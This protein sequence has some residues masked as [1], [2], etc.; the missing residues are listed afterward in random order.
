MIIIRVNIIGAGS[1]GLLFAHQ[2]Q[3]CGHSIHISTRSDEQAHTL[4]KNGV[5]APQS[6]AVKVAASQIDKTTFNES[7]AVIIAVKQYHLNEI[8]PALRRV[9]DHI[10]LIFLQNGMSHLTYLSS[11]PHKHIFVSTVEHGS[12]KLNSHTYQHNGIGWWRIACYRGD[13]KLVDRFTAC[14]RTDFPVAF[15]DNYEILLTVKLIKNL[16]INPLTALFNVRNGELEANARYREMMKLLYSEIMF[17][18]PEAVTHCR[19]DDIFDLCMK[20]AE[21]ESSMLSDIKAGRKTE[22]E[23]MTGYATKIAEEKKVKPLIIPFLENAILAIQER[24]EKN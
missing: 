9:P 21:N 19:L 5:T 15:E 23:A 8:L 20:T 6:Q 11:I 18:F 3:I 17:I 1:I 14:N 22:I 16:M 7:E 4:N 2:L 13:S 12:K 10:P 24:E